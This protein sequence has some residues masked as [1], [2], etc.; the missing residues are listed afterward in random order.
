MT[1]LDALSDL[2]ASYEDKHHAIEPASDADLLRR[3]MVAK[4]VSQT[5]IS[6]DAGRPNSTISEVLARKKT[7]SRHLIR[8]LA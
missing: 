2:I 5:E 4:R 8:K 1:N 3:L 7:F 6:R